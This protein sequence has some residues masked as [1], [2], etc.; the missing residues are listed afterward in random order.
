MP[1]NYISV[2][3]YLLFL[4]CLIEAALVSVPDFG[5]NP[6]GL[7]MS[8]YVPAKLATSPAVILAVSDGEINSDVMVDEFSA[9]WLLRKWVNIFTDDQI[10][11]PCRNLWLYRDI[12]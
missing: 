1:Q 6:T 2:T 10:Y 3:L 4:S 8:I 12:S 9:P 11:F 7:Q 5:S